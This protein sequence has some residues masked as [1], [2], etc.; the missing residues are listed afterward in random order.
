[1]IHI[2]VHG[3]GGKGRGERGIK[4]Y[5]PSNFFAKFVNKNAIK[6]QKSVPYPKKFSQSLLTLLPKFGENLMDPPPVFS[7]H[8]HLWF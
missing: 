1:L 5:P 4:V 2:G 6:H 7:N 3:G 8:V